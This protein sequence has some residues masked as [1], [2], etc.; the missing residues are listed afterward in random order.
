[1]NNIEFKDVEQKIEEVVED[2]KFLLRKLQE[3]ESENSRYFKVVG[4]L[5]MK[6]E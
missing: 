5:Y 6:N 2:N 4:N 1:M 3:L